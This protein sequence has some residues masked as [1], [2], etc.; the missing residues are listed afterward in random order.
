MQTPSAPPTLLDSLRKAVDE[1]PLTKVELAQRAGMSRKTLFSI[2]EGTT[3]YKVSSL[4]ALAD[5][6]EID[7]LLVPK[8]VREGRLGEA[9]TSEHSQYSRVGAFLRSIKS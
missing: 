2:L 4:L 5:A 3:D 9:A 1:S 8:V 7:V 6:L